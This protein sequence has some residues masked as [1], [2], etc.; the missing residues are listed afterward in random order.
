MQN[1]ISDCIHTCRKYVYYRMMVLFVKNNHKV[2]LD[3]KD[4]K[5]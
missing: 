2:N 3:E 4:N 1:N 5:A